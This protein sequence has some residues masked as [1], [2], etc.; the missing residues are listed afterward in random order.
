[1]YNSD[2]QERGHTSPLTSGARKQHWPVGATQR[3]G[4]P[5]SERLIRP[6]PAAPRKIDNMMEQSRLY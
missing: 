2:Q 1:M 5:H 3:I 6:I 4:P